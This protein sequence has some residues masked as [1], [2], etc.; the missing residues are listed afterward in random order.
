M[1]KELQTHAEGDETNS[2]SPATLPNEH[3]HV[4]FESSASS[5][6]KQG[7]QRKATPLPQPMKAKE[8]TTHC[9]EDEEEDDKDMDDDAPMPLKESERED[10]FAN[11][12]PLPSYTSSSIPKQG[13]Q[14]KGTPLPKAMKARAHGPLFVPFHEPPG[15][16]VWF[17]PSGDQH[18]IG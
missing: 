8:Q 7:L 1:S 6:P 3:H 4:H 12:V 11:D 18:P 10:I 9:E 5:I 2:E 17:V 16:P 13:L 14:R 15:T